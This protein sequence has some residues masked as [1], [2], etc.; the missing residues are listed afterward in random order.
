VILGET[1]ER[2]SGK[3]MAAYFRQALKFDALQLK[4]TYWETLEA[5]PAG[6]P[7]RAHQY[8]GSTDVTGFDPSLDLYG[9]G[10]LVSTTSDLDRFF[11]AL[12]TGRL[13]QHPSTLSMALLPVEPQQ[14]MEHPRALL[15]S[16]RSFGKRKCWAHGGYW[17]TAA[18]YCPDIDAAISTTIDQTLD[19]SSAANR[20]QLLE[21]LAAVLDRAVENG[22]RASR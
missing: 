12:L 13:F 22:A 19:E 21:G 16:A 7:A 9:G 3:P 14:P 17:G 10:G 11:R 15:L 20:R 1:I 5:A 2:A 18:M 6:L 8:W 4:S